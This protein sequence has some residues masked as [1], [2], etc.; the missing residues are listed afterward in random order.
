[1]TVAYW[2]SVLIH[3]AGLDT[4][5][6]QIYTDVSPS[7]YTNMIATSEVISPNF[8]PSTQPPTKEL[9]RKQ[10]KTHFLQNETQ[11]LKNR[12]KK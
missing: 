3:T 1:M 9:C 5:F 4:I 11:T 7:M 8:A 12:K 2:A 6:V 10:N